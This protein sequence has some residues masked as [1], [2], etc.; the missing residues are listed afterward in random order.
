M[1]GWWYRPFAK[2]RLLDEMYMWDAF[3]TLIC[4]GV[5]I[6]QTLNIT[7]EVSPRYAK[8]IQ[9]IH[10]AVKEGDRITTPLEK[11]DKSFHPVALPLIDVG[12][13]TGALPD[14][15][16]KIRDVID[17]DLECG[18]N[19]KGWGWLQSDVMQKYA[20]LQCCSTM[21]D[22]GLPLCR[23]LEKLERVNYLSGMK[24]TLKGMN[25]DIQGGA[26][27]SEAMAVKGKK[28][29]NRAD[30]NMIRAGEAGGV[31]DVTMARMADYTRRRYI[32]KR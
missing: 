1:A 3:G 28:H 10:D 23:V 26:T 29:F 11:Y 5:P 21:I 4:S 9:G 13:E 19:M 12:E 8:E 17:S 24:E 14:M 6:L 25:D 27:F 32:E 2:K 15:L 31:L 22:A 16:H 30:V 7:K 18:I 20:F